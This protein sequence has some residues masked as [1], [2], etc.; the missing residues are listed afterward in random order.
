MTLDAIRVNVGRRFPDWLVAAVADLGEHA[1]ESVAVLAEILRAAG[2]RAGRLSYTPRGAAY[3]NLPGVTVVVLS[4]GAITIAATL[5]RPGER[6]RA[7]AAR[8]AEMLAA[9]FTQGTDTGGRVGHS[10]K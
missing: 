3:A 1:P 8:A 7:R 6:P 4:S 5:D 2:A 10:G 9:G